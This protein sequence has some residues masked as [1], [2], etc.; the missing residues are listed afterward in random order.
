M[1]RYEVTVG[2]FR[3]FVEA[4]GY[5]T[6][7]ERAD[8]CYGWTGDKWKKKSE[9]S[10]RNP[11]FVQG[12]EH[13]VACVS[14]ND[15]VAYA[16]WLSN[17]TGKRYRLPTEAQWEYA[18]RAG[19]TTARYWGDEPDDAC[20]YANVGDRSAKRKYT[21]LAVHDCDD[22]HVHTAP[23]GSFRANRFGLH[24]MLGNLWEW[25]CS[26]HEAS[27]DGSEKRCM[28]KNYAARRVIRGGSWYSRPRFVRSAYRFGF[29]AD[30]RYDGVGFRLAQD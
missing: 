18:A 26:A 21:K 10:W 9:F 28:S 30:D 15:A 8:G 24:D 27:Y 16:E 5:R 11:G 1:G 3:R 6:E 13:P 25:T 19:M 22:G 20:W 7:A 4:S 12:G 17:K 14:W 23:A 2:E 29:T